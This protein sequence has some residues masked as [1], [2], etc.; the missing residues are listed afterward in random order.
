MARGIILLLLSAGGNTGVNLFLDFWGESII[1]SWAKTI[2]SEEDGS[3]VCHES[4]ADESVK[5]N[6]KKL[7][8]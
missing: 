5:G 8:L 7:V 6:L 3:W 4:D 1:R 2:K